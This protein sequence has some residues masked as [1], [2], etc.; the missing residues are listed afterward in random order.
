[1]K[2][3]FSC[4]LYVCLLLSLT[5][6]GAPAATTTQAPAV[7][8]TLPASSPA[9]QPSV[10]A[11]SPT[12]QPTAKTVELVASYEMGEGMLLG[13]Q[14]L[15]GYRMSFTYDAGYRSGT[16]VLDL[17][18]QI[19]NG[20]FTCDE[21][22]NINR[23]Q[24]LEEGAQVIFEITFDD[25][26]RK[27]SARSYVVEN[28]VTD[29]RYEET[30]RYDAQGRTVYAKR[31]YAGEMS[32][33]TETE[34][35]EAGLVTRQST[36]T[37]D[38]TASHSSIVVSEYNEKNIL[39]AMHYYDGQG[40]LMMTLPFTHTPDG[41]NTRC[42]ADMDGAKMVMLVNP[43]GK[44][45]RTEMHNADGIYNWLESEFDLQGRLVLQKQWSV[46]TGSVVT[47]AYTYT[48]DNRLISQIN[49]VED[50]MT[51]VQWT[52]FITVEIAQ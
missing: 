40:Q 28:G 12:T 37:T 39:S 29:V 23:I 3:L 7:P 13:N 27:L 43:Q 6:C 50:G 20:S 24:F 9:T 1:M 17:D 22:Y 31:D 52:E 48:A 34:Y 46:Y 47:T 32:Q 26:H 35:N 11:T 44:A 10:P 5:A 2:R 45:I 18:G 51:I 36:V 38:G 16:V 41:E 8:T 25:A 21:N 30:F 19:A 42:T 15:Y 14:A 33:L 49:T 4:L